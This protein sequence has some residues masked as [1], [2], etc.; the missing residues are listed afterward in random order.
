VADDFWRSGR[1]GVI[2]LPS[3]TAHARLAPR[4]ED[5]EKLLAVISREALSI[6]VSRTAWPLPAAAICT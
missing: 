6:N 1:S 5:R 3:N 4:G 2:G